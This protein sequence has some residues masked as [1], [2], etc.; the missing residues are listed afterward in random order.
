MATLQFILIVGAV[1]VGIVWA[2]D[3]PTTKWEGFK[4]PRKL[5]LLQILERLAGIQE[6]DNRETKPPANTYTEAFSRM[7]EREETRLNKLANRTDPP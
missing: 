2:I 7:Q 4:K 3:I 6:T 5:S 1:V